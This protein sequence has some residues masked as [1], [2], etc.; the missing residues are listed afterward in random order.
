VLGR[1]G[2]ATLES[3]DSSTCCNTQTLHPT[4]NHH[5]SSFEATDTMTDTKFTHSKVTKGTK[6]FHTFDIFSGL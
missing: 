5:N 1:S 6:K 4:V 3:K 2:A